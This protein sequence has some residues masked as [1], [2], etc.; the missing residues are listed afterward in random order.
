MVTHSTSTEVLMG[1]ISIDKTGVPL[2]DE[3]LEQAKTVT[4]FYW[5]CRRRYRNSNL[6]TTLIYRGGLIGTEKG[7][8]LFA[9]LRPVYTLS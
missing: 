1:G 5:G 9:N 3:A 8:G 2:T 6:S 4:R 7:L